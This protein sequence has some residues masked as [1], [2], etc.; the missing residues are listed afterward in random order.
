MNKKKRILIITLAILFFIFLLTLF[1]NVYMVNGTKDKIIDLD[2]IG[3]VSDIDAIIILGCK[4]EDGIPSLMLRNRLEKG[5]DVYRKVHTKIIVSGNHNDHYNE[6]DVMKDYLVNSSVLE[7]DIFED[8]AGLSTYDSIYRAKNIFEAKKVIIVTQE[9]HLYRALYLANKLEIDA[10]G[11][12]ADDI[13]QKGIMLKNKIREVFSR[14]KNF[15]LGIIKPESTFM[16]D[17]IPL[18]HSGIVSEG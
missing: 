17:K 6:V 8:H 5:I 9:Y 16:G 10:I 12:A 3:D 7:E 13:P 18:N 1:I 4:V 2:S 15:F 11:V 14:D